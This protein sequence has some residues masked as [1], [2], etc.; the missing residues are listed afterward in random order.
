MWGSQRLSAQKQKDNW[1][2]RGVVCVKTRTRGVVSSE[3]PVFPTWT[4]LSGTNWTI[5]EETLEPLCMADA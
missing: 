4:R 1:K 2:T 3:R 5:Q